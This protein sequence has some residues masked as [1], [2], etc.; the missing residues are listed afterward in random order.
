MAPY[1]LFQQ[2]PWLPS[3]V[4]IDV[5]RDKLN[6]RRH[7]YHLFEWDTRFGRIFESRRFVTVLLCACNFIQFHFRHKGKTVFVLSPSTIIYRTGFMKSSAI[8]HI[9][10]N[11]VRSVRNITKHQFYHFAWHV[12]DKLKILPVHLTLTDFY[13]LSLSFSSGLSFCLLFCG[14]KPKIPVRL[15]LVLVFKLFLLTDQCTV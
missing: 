3:T 10:G 12:S 6:A 14:N 13:S 2:I 11:S 1:F 5:Q 9:H 4:N 7:S 15:L 8:H